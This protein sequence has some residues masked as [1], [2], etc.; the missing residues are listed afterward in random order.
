M[1]IRS[2]MEDD[3]ERSNYKSGSA[4]EDLVTIRVVLESSGLPGVRDLI[5]ALVSNP[6]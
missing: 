4:S 3:P 6:G 1:R 5:L 2:L